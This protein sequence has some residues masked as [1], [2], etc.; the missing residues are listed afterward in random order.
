MWY[1][2]SINITCLTLAYIDVKTFCLKSIIHLARE[3]ADRKIYGWLNYSNLYLKIAVH[4]FKNCG[5]PQNVMK[6]C[7]SNSNFAFKI[8][9][10]ATL[11]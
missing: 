2:E 9:K 8:A 7:C 6:N 5:I 3:M 10:T 1:R 4:H 11:H